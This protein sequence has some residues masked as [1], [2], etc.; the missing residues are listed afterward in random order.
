MAASYPL[1]GKTLFVTGGANGIGAASAR[2][3]S[4]RGARVAL[5]DVQLE[6][7]EAVA[8]ELPDAIAVRADVR[9]MDSLEAA[10]QAT[11]DAFGGIDVVMANAGVGTLGTVEGLS[12]DEV[13]RIIDINFTGVFRTVKAALPH[14]LERRGYVLITA[15]L[16]AIAHT[17]PLTHYAA[18]KAGVEA[19]GNSLRIEVASRGVDVGIAY[20]GVIGTSMVESAYDHPVLSA[21][22]DAHPLRG[23]LGKTYPVTGAGKAVARGIEKRARRVMYPRFLRGL[24]W[25]RV[26]MPRLSEKA[27]A[28]EDV[29]ELVRML[30]DTG[31]DSPAKAEAA[32][33]EQ[34][35]SSKD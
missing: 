8:A 21:F 5:V 17:P 11:V 19:F 10:V 32:L 30:N 35:G 25:I 18:T 4:K 29:G 20:F 13:E 9:D 1:A 15:S 27:T 22:R 3:A 31:G 33:A 12:M 28:H 26:G 7:A 34:L 23:P 16:A 6:A 2:E 24:H 14:V